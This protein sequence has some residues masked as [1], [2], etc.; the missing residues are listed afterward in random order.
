[1]ENSAS[2]AQYLSLAEAAEIKGVNQDYLRLLIFRKKLRAIKFGRNW[3]ISQEWLDEYFNPRINHIVTG[4]NDSV[5]DKEHTRIPKQAIT[6]FLGGAMTVFAF[7]VLASPYVS[8][9]ISQ[10]PSGDRIEYLFFTKTGRAPLQYAAPNLTELSRA[11]MDLAYGNF[12]GARH[13]VSRSVPIPISWSPKPFTRITKADIYQTFSLL[14]KD[15]RES[16]RTIFET[17]EI[18]KEEFAV[19]SFSPVREF[20]STFFK[21]LLIAIVGDNSEKSTNSESITNKRI[22]RRR[23]FQHSTECWN[24]PGQPDTGCRENHHPRIG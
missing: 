22:V 7:G 20:F 18:I 21:N 16:P 8:S 23:T 14:K 19:V 9:F 2:S 15:F 10:V 6:L 5:T 4:S 12:M 1:M 24:V 3:V 17:K 13:S 11:G